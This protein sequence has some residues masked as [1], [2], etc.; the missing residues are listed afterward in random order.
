MMSLAPISWRQL[1]ATIGAIVSLNIKHQWP[2]SAIIPMVSLALINAPPLHSQ[3]T[4]ERVMRVSAFISRSYFGTIALLWHS[5]GAHI[6]LWA[7]IALLVLSYCAHF[8]KNAL[9]FAD[10]VLITWAQYERVFLMNALQ[11]RYE[12]VLCYQRAQITLIATLSCSECD[13]STIGAP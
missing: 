4:H 13:M 12:R 3:C 11:E 9:M 2:I 5:Y 7:H 10:M 1:A 8:F 6:T